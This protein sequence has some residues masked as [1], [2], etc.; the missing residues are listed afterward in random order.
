MIQT[1][2]RLCQATVSLLMKKSLSITFS[3]RWSITF[4]KT[5]ILF[6]L[7][8][9][10]FYRSMKNSRERVSEAIIPLLMQYKNND[11]FAFHQISSRLG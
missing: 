7:N 1:L 11:P 10:K 9:G 8:D 3:D 4:R 5:V 6:N 2:A